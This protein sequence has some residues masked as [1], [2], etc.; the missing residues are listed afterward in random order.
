VLLTTPAA[1][2][3]RL[4]AVQCADEVACL[5]TSRR[6]W[7]FRQWQSD[8]PLSNAGA[9]TGTLRA[10]YRQAEGWHATKATL[11]LFER[12]QP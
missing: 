8:A 6:V 11:V 7:F 5:G 10:D 3:G 12:R 1:R 2:V 4:D 9:L